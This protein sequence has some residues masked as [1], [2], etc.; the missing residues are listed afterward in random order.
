MQF[1]L[2]QIM[3][4]CILYEQKL[5]SVKNLGIIG[6]K[7]KACKTSSSK[8]SVADAGDAGQRAV[9]DAEGDT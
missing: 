4:S 2:G 7:L 6:I 1:I 9:V 5:F 3:Q 8:L